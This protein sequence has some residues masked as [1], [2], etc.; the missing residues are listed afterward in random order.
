MLNSIIYENEGNETQFNSDK[1]SLENYIENNIEKNTE[2]T[3]EK[4]IEKNKNIKKNVFTTK[5]KNNKNT[6]TIDLAFSLLNSSFYF[7]F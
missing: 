1:K 5:N 3:T 2:E 4:N 7:S 6:S